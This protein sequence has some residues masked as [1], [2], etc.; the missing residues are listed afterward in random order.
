MKCKTF[1]RFPY[2]KTVRTV[3][4]DVV[5]VIP[6]DDEGAGHLGGNDTAGQDT[7]TDG[8][9]TSEGALLV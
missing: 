3:L 4:G 5:K 7:T 9:V 2:S 6:T 8:D 1:L